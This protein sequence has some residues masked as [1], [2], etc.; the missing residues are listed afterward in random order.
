[1]FRALVEKRKREQTLV[2]H[3]IGNKKVPP[4]PF[5]PRMYY[6]TFLVH[7]DMDYYATNV[8]IEQKGPY[9]F[10]SKQRAERFVVYSLCKVLIGHFQ[11]DK[12][13]EKVRLPILNALD[14]GKFTA[15]DLYGICECM[16]ENLYGKAN[17]TC[18]ISWTIDLV[19]QVDQ[20]TNIDLL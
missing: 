6:V 13:E 9:I 12:Q 8:V 3:E 4:P 11:F 10:S 20:N 17:D 2:Q 1:M 15:P 7:D 14:K 5:D 19:P 16:V 18:G